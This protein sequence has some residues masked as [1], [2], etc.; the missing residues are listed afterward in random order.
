MSAGVGGRGGGAGGVSQKVTDGQ[1]S[2]R[3]RHGECN[4]VG[5]EGGWGRG[6]GGGGNVPGE[7]K[8]RTLASI[9]DGSLLSP[10]APPTTPVS[11]ATLGR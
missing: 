4:P 2:D 7:V 5:G 9:K 6:K 8:E 11:Q 1:E 3:W 10:D